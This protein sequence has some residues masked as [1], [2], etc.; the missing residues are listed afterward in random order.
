MSRRNALLWLLPGC[1]NLAVAFIP[2]ADAITVLNL[3]V[4]AW[5]FYEAFKPARSE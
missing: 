4:A 2:P 1:V 5:C 3:C